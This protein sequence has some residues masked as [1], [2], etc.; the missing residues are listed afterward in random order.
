ME[1]FEDTVINGVPLSYLEG[2]IDQN[3]FNK[4]KELKADIVKAWGFVPNAKIKEW[5]LLKEGDLVLFYADKSF[6]HLAVVH[7]K[8]HNQEVAKSLWGTDDK[9]RTWEYMFFIKEGKS[10]QLPFNPT[11]LIKKD[12]ENYASNYVVQGALLLTDKNADAMKKYLEEK[13]GTSFD[14]DSIEPTEEEEIIFHKRIREPNSVEEAMVE[15]SRISTETKDSPVREK[16]KTAR[17][18]VRNPKFA[19]LVKEK[20]K[21]VCEICGESPFT[22]KNGLPYAEAHHKSE[23]S[24]KK[25]DNPSDMICVCANCHKVVHFGTEEE[26]KKRANKKNLSM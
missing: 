12:L 7:S 5:E 26:L 25:I 2:R 20:A 16:I 4:I 14:D 15:I 22:Q 11:I 10:I 21:Y 3:D 13:E 8:T 6:F 19:R 1:H 17:M 18:L 9:D 24:K 23:L